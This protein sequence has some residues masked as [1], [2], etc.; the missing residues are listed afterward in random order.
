MRRAPKLI[1]AV[2]LTLFWGACAAGCVSVPVPPS[3]M[4]NMKAGQL[5]R[6]EARVVVAYKPNWQGVA[7][8]ATDRLF[9]KDGYSK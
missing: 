2:I 3:D 6:I 9:K 5:G 8:A 1:A 4:G 7:Q